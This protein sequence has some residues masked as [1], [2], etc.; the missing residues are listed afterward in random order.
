MPDLA[1]ILEFQDPVGDV[2]AIW[3]GGGEGVIR[4]GSQLIVREGQT[5]LFFRD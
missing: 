1:D 2:L 5:A 3:H 4:W